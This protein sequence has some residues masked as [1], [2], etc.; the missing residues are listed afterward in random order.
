MPADLIP[1]VLRTYGLLVVDD[2]E[3]QRRHLVSNLNALGISRVAEAADGNHALDLLE[4]LNPLP[5]ALI[6]DLEMP[7]MDGIELIQKL[8]ERRMSLPLIVASSREAVMISSTETM[9]SGLGLP[10]LGALSK[11]VAVPDLARALRKIDQYGAGMPD[12]QPE[13]GVPVEALREALAQQRIQPFFQP[14]ASVARAMVRSTEAL[15]RWIEP[16]SSPIPPARFIP[17]A[18]AHG[19]MAEL[20]LTILDQSIA[21][22]RLWN[23]RGVQ[24]P[25]A[26]NLSPASLA[27]TVLTEGLIRRVAA[28]GLDA[29]QFIFEVTESAMMGGDAAATACLLRLRLR[30][31]G[32]SIDDYGTGFSSMQQLSRLPFTELK[33]DRGFVTGAHARPPLRTMLASAI[34]MAGR[35]GLSTV[36][37]GVE[38][39]EDWALL[40]E[41]GCELA[42]GYLIARPL[43]AEEFLHE[44]PQINHR[45]R[46]LQ[47]ER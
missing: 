18:E 14:K 10:L 39:A 5:A 26:I 33:V 27:D 44:L 46:G 40:R 32:L 23:S 7:G 15:A 34:D 45:L 37:E 36:A 42:Q 21:A 8:A 17:V 22:M 6:V 41:L 3:V 2:S 12:T 38:T 25:V 11:P 28:S 4:T 35:L 47:A 16:A 19:L 13:T 9:I 29:R 1:D 20:T 43:P 31:C 24:L 30:G